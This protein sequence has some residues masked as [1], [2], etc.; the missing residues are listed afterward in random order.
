MSRFAVSALVLSL[1][2]ASALGQ[3][4][5]INHANY[6]AI[7][8]ASQA[9]CDE[10]G[11]LRIFFAHASIGYDIASGMNT[12]R[13]SDPDRYQIRIV[14]DDGTPPAGTTPGTLYRYDR[15]NPGWSA[16]LSGFN[17]YVANGWRSPN[18]DIAINKFCFIDADANVNSYIASMSALESANPDTR[19]VYVTVPL[20][21]GSNTNNYYRSVFNNT[22]RQWAADNDKVLFDLADIEAWDLNGIEQSFIQNDVHC[23]KMAYDYTSDY[24]H[25]NTAAG[26]LRV[27]KGMYSL[28]AAM[29]VPEPASLGLLAAGAVALLRRRRRQG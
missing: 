16:K 22:L 27:A 2:A 20:T 10:V 23:Q 3:G 8:S 18:V 9:V 19:F 11:Q 1:A 28:Y 5:V 24:Q 17:N 26:R 6:D 12:L 29:V 13:G 7:D 14:A 4:I 21:T 25:P 15:G